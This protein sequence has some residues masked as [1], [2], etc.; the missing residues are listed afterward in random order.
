[1][2]NHKQARLPHQARTPTVSMNDYLDDHASDITVE[3]LQSMGYFPYQSVDEVQNLIDTIKTFT[4][5]VFS[6]VSKE[7]ETLQD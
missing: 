3:A 7:E 5:I 1:M 6:I 2:V 4:E